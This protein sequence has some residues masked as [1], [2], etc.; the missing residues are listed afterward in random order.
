M[1][2]SR[3]LLVVLVIAVGLLLAACGQES[4]EAAPD[5]PAVVEEIDGS[6]LKRITLTSRAAERLGIETAPVEE[7]TVGGRE[8]LVVPYGAIL[9]DAE[10][11]SW[12]YT[13]TDSLKFVREEIVVDRIDG[14]EAVLSDGPTPGTLVVTVGAAELWGTETGVGGSG[15]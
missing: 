9:Y 1:S 3:S 10:G 11:V 13:S 7:K 2:R 12:A 8:A 6:A 15:H 5:A 4:A 14:D